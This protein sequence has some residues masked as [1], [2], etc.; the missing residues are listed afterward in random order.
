MHRESKSYRFARVEGYRITLA[1][2]EAQFRD[3]AVNLDEMEAAAA[4]Q[5][6]K[7]AL[8]TPWR[9]SAVERAGCREGVRQAVAQFLYQYREALREITAGP[10]DFLLFSSLPFPTAGAR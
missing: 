10:E 2:L 7:E 6:A 1:H 8:P 5:L 3:R 9:Q 4:K